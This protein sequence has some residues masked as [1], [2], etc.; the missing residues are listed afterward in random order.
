MFPL[1]PECVYVVVLFFPDKHHNS[2]LIFI[3]F[4]F[5]GQTRLAWS[6]WFTWIKGE[7]FPET[8]TDKY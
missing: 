1:S 3:P 8:E 6:T 7:L 5:T 2:C 4:F